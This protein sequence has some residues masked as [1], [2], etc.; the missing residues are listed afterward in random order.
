[1]PY[2][3]MS[4]DFSELSTTVKMIACLLSN[5]AMASGWNLVGVWEGKGRGFVAFDVTCVEFKNNS[6]FIMILNI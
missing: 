1:M 2:L 5:V 3:F 6:I 4:E